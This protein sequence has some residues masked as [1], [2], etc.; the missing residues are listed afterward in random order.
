MKDFWQAYTPVARKGATIV[1]ENRYANGNRTVDVH[2][3]IPIPNI[4]I[5]RYLWVKA[6]VLW[7]DYWQLSGDFHG[8]RG[9]IF[10]YCHVRTHTLFHQ[11]AVIDL[12]LTVDD[13]F[14]LPFKDKDSH[15][16]RFVQ[17]YLWNGEPGNSH[18]EYV[19]TWEQ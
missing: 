8:T 6:L 18:T 13:K 11:V 17:P 5:L 16:T 10:P 19:W 3:E 1:T 4:P 9:D 14:E 7:T 12:F 15:G 2:T